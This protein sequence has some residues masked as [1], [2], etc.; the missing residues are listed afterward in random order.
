MM[1][2][3]EKE[4]KELARVRML[5]EVEQ[6]DR[7]VSIGCWRLPQNITGSCPLFQARGEAVDSLIAKVHTVLCGLVF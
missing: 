1:A 4:L 6:A 7:Q 2:R 5:R 3:S